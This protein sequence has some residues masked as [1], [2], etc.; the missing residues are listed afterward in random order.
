MREKVVER[1]CKQIVDEFLWK[2]LNDL[3]MDW[4]L[5]ERKNSTVAPGSVAQA[6]GQRWSQWSR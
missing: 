2:S 3:L 6:A 4:M 5:R 1:R